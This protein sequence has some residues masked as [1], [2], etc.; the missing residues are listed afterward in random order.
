M[1]QMEIPQQGTGMPQ[2][3]LVALLTTILL[4]NGFI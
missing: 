2:L 3:E 4:F 1:M